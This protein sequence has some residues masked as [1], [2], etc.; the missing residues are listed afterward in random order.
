M[1]H[2]SD[3]NSHTPHALK[4][5][6]TEYQYASND[7]QSCIMLEL[8]LLEYACTYGIFSMNMFGTRLKTNLIENDNDHHFLK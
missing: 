2:I 8:H 6:Q 1:Y 3:F 5:I 7:L 4:D